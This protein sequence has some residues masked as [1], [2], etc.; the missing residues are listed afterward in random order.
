MCHVSHLSPAVS[1]AVVTDWRTIKVGYLWFT[2]WNIPTIYHSIFFLCKICNLLMLYLHSSTMSRFTWDWYRSR[3][4]RCARGGPDGDVICCSY[5]LIDHKNCA[6]SLNFHG[7]PIR[8]AHLAHTDKSGHRR[9]IVRELKRKGTSHRRDEVYEHTAAHRPTSP[10]Q[11]IYGS[12]H[13]NRVYQQ[14]RQ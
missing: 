3:L 9:A 11:L 14:A 4:N 12:S 8:D 6:R 13:T 1:H 10:K 5:R 7:N 2:P